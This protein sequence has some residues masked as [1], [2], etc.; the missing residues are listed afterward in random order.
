MARKVDGRGSSSRDVKVA[1]REATRTRKASKR[2][3]ADSRFP[4]TLLEEALKVP[5]VIKEKNGGNPWA[6]EQVASALEM[7]HKANP[8]F[9]LAAASRDYGLTEG[10]R[11]TKSIALAPMGR[12]IVYAPNAEIEKESKTKAFLSV[13]I[14][15]SVLEYYNGSNLPEMKYLGNTLEHQ[16]GLPAEAHEDFSRVFRENCRFLGIGSGFVAS[17]SKDGETKPAFPAKASP[18]VVTVAEPSKD[19]GLV[20]FV[21]MPFIERQESHPKG[22]FQ[23]VLQ[24]L[25]TPAARDVGFRVK[26]AN[27]QGS[28]VIQSTIINDLLE[29][30]LVIADLTEHNPNVLFE[31]GVRMAIDKPV[32]VIKAKGTGQ[33]FDVDNMLRFQEYDGNLWRTTIERDL[34]LL[35]AHIKGTWE[36]R[37]TARSYMKILRQP[38]KS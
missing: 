18:T 37:E 27:R 8:F 26:T 15:K 20:A 22:F 16:F 31:L 23:E 25:I 35:G 21:I 17:G 6:P 11:D 4:R 32:A 7:S 2:G 19:T 14:F 10:S 38:N 24:S 3:K 28:D 34:P 1:A 9:Y 13:P 36:S 12:E 33:V 5:Q 29:A 30:D